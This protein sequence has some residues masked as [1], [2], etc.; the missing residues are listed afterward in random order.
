MD[1]MEPVSARI[2][3]K[4]K[5]IIRGIA[6]IVDLSPAQ[7]IR[8]IIT[9]EIDTLLKEKKIYYSDDMS[10]CYTQSEY[11]LIQKYREEHNKNPIRHFFQKREDD[12][13]L[14]EAYLKAKK[15][16]VT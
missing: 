15:R 7:V 12:R 14:K 3:L 9:K 2:P 1:N 16:E 8:N 4:Y 11:D 13:K 6:E 10:E 5:Y